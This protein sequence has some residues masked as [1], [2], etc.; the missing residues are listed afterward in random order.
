MEERLD[1]VSGSRNHLCFIG[2]IHP[3]DVFIEAVGS[4]HFPIHTSILVGEVMDLIPFSLFKFNV[5][6]LDSP[7]F[8]A[9]VH[10]FGILFLFLLV[11]GGG[12]YGGKLPCEG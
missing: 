8:H 1:R 12:C 3:I 5:S 11:I 4:G 2:S 7:Y 6:H 9:L 10:H